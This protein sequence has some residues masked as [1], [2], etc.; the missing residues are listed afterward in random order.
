MFNVI[1]VSIE[2]IGGPDWK[3]VITLSVYSINKVL[4]LL[5]LNKLYLS[6]CPRPACYIKFMQTTQP[7]SA[8][9]IW[10]R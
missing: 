3:K 8:N 2:F 4:L 10:D 1:V 6:C 5:L 9:I 7:S